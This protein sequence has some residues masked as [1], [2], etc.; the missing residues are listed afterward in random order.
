MSVYQEW[1][2]TRLSIRRLCGI[3]DDQPRDKETKED[4][5]KNGCS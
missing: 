3:K 4:D 5:E 2:E 1:D